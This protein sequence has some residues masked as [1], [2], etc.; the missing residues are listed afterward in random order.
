LRKRGERHS[1]HRQKAYRSA[2]PRVYEQTRILLN[3]MSH[4][5]PGMLQSE[6]RSPFEPCRGRRR[7][8]EYPDRRGIPGSNPHDSLHPFVKSAAEKL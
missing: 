3:Q 7:L 8:A 6:T 1:Q 2:E 4:S 5:L